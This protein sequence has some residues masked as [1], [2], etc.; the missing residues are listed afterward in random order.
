MTGDEDDGNLDTRVS[1]LTLKVQT[2]D[3]GKS[4][5]QDQATWPIRPLAS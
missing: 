2:V 1:Q 5:V 4:H 3:S